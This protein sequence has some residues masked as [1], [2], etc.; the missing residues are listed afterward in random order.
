[1]HCIV[2]W[3]AAKKKTMSVGKSTEAAIE[4]CHCITLEML[5]P[6]GFISVT[7]V[8]SHFTFLFNFD[9]HLDSTN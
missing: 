3:P 5:E 7:I 2:H 6:N 4:V 8:V 1:M 9:S